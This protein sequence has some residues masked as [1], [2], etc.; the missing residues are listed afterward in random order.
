[1]EDK[2]ANNQTMYNQIP[3]NQTPD[4][5]AN[6]QTMYNP[7]AYNQTA[8]NQTVNSGNTNNGVPIIDSIL[9]EINE[10]FKPKEKMNFTALRDLP[11]NTKLNIKQFIPYET[12]YGDK[13]LIELSVIQVGKEIT[14]NVFLP[15]R[16]K[17]MSAKYI[18]FLSTNPNIYF[19]YTGK[20][21]EGRHQ[22]NWT[23]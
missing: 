21:R 8:N 7:A 10:E 19:V 13:L 23:E 16:Y 11:Q 20:D 15:D 14:F 3:N 1:M 9:R 17:K 22:I 2:T 18:E 6:N 5:T 12:K 4:K